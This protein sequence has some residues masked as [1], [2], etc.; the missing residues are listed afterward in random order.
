M[1]TTLDETQVAVR[2]VAADV[3]GR[4]TDPARVEKVEATP[5]RFDRELWTSIAETGLLGV[6]VPE[7]SGGLG[8]GAVELTLVLEQWGRSVAPVPFP[9][10]LL[11]SWLLATHG[12]D[13][14]RS[15]WLPELLA[16][17]A[18]VAVASPASTVGVRVADG[19][20]DGSA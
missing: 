4:R 8:L 15:R 1:N 20:L 5:D 2:D 18:V 3:F 17:S 13:A 10:T 11:A 19:R 16:G 6:V 12:D 9:V 14:Q 7:E